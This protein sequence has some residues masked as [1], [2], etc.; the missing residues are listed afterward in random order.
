MKLPGS[1]LQAFNTAPINCLR[2]NLLPC[3][4]LLLS[5]CLACVAVR[6]GFGKNFMNAG[7][8]QWGVGAMQ[9]D[10][11]DAVKW[12]VA[13]GIADPNKVGVPQG[14][15][16][17]AG[18]SGLQRRPL[19]HS[20]RPCTHLLVGVSATGLPYPPHIC[21]CVALCGCLCRTSHPMTSTERLHRQ[22][23]TEFDNLL[24]TCL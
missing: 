11:T 15:N 4:P 5:V 20:K 14:I 18:N 8:K 3:L 10:L 7:I 21:L 9:H 1:L 19:C 13:K 23:C 12:A 2:T 6:P 16:A 24:Q 17:K 22:M